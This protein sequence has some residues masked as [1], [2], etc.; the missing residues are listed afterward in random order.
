M[1]EKQT[2]QKIL[3]AA[4]EIFMRKGMHGAKMQ[5]IADEAGI[6]KALLHYYFRSKDKLFD[7]IFQ[8]VFGQ[9]F[10]KLQILVD[11]TKSIEERVQIFVKEYMTVMQQNP[12]LPLFILHEI[13]RDP[14]SLHE[15]FTSTGLQ[16]EI[17]MQGMSAS[18][19]MTVD[20]V[21]MFLV[22]MLSLCIFPFAAKPLLSRILYAGD[23]KA[24]D[25]FLEERKL[26]VPEFILNSL[27]NQ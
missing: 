2:E 4:R 27:K 1:T 9:L 12:F 25:S 14:D 17:V 13:Q 10:P 23:D 11:A 24:Y 18:L 5:E 15:R 7:R 19:D 3:D 22:N 6:N 26:S 8:E 20:E 21:K 16:P